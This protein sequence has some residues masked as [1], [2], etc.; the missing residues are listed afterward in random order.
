MTDRRHPRIVYCRRCSAVLASATLHTHRRT[1]DGGN[2]MIFPATSD[3]IAAFNAERL[4]ERVERERI[5]ANEIQ[6]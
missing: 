5:E 1:C 3:Q 4:A 6:R 2:E